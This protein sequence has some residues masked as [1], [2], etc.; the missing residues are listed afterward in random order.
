MQPE[1]LYLVTITPQ[2]VKVQPP[3]G[4]PEEVL[5]KDINEIRLVNTDAG[6]F[7]PD[8]W[9][10]LIGD[11]ATG[12][13]IPHGNKDFEAVYDIISKF[14]KFSF[15]NFIQSMSSMQNEEFVLWKK[16]WIEPGQPKE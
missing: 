5:W 3:S 16:E 2:S 15:D 1:D 7:E 4:D 6:P 11:N 14:E 9:L 8:I 10:V 12:C 13:M